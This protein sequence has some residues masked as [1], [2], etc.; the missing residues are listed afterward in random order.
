MMEKKCPSGEEQN[1]AKNKTMTIP[2]S[3][4]RGEEVGQMI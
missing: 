2:N 3:M 4:H 1:E